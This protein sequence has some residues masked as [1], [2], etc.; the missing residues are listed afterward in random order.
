MAPGA[1]RRGLSLAETI[2]AIFLLVASFLVITNLFH[3]GLRYIHKVEARH[4]AVL[5]AQNKIEE[6]RDWARLAANFQA[7][8]TLDGDSG[9]DTLYPGYT[10]RLEVEDLV[11]RSPSTRMEEIAPGQERELRSTLK[12]LEVSVDWE[13]ESITLVTYVAAP[14]GEWRPTTPLVMTAVGGIPNPVPVGGTIDFQVQGFGTSGPLDDLM[15][16]WSVRPLTGNG[17]ITAQ[18]RDGRTATFQNSYLGLSTGGTVEVEVRAVYR[19]QE[20]IVGSGVIN[21]AGP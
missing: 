18:S 17:T 7:F 4:L 21:L 9:S 2:I 8:G 14:T 11:A 5:V 10:W 15:F 3:A 19:G 6:V 12:K 20:R 1:S 16:R 13:T